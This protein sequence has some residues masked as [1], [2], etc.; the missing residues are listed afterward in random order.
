MKAVVLRF[1]F[2]VVISLTITVLLAPFG[3]Q[4]LSAQTR[5]DTLPLTIQGSVVSRP[6]GSPLA[7]AVIRVGATAMVVSGEGGGFRLEGIPPGTHRVVVTCLGHQPLETDV[8]FSRS[9]S[10]V[11]PLVAVEPLLATGEQGS[12]RGRLRVT[13]GE[14]STEGGTVTLP[15][16]GLARITGRDGTFLFPEVPAGTHAVTVALLGYSERR[17]SVEVVAGRMTELDIP[18]FVE[19]IPLEGITVTARP[20]WI[21][22]TGLF[23]RLENRNAY[24]GRAWTR[25]EIERLDPVFVQDLVESLPGVSYDPVEGY[26]A[27]RRGCRLALYIDDAPMPGFDLAVL[28]PRQIEAIEVYYGGGLRIP[29]EYGSRHCGVILVWLRH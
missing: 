8:T 21:V 17:E 9:G 15:E 1:L 28:D 3:H 29:A 16:L 12:I 4:P 20:R 27:Q 7:G 19:P 18:L 2:R 11:L 10:L 23:R 13:G 22:S 25:E 5:P 6:S 14:G 24:T 26:R